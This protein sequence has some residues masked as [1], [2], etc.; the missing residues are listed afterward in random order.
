[1][2]V[3]AAACLLARRC[4]GQ[5]GQRRNTVMGVT[6]A[7]YVQSPLSGDGFTSTVFRTTVQ[8]KP[9]AASGS[10]IVEA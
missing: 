4:K 5:E 9:F 6:V 3:L 8:V 7:G 1:M 2:G 10:V